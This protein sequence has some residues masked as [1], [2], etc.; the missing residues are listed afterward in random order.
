MKL[1]QKN[2]FRLGEI[3]QQLSCKNFVDE[4][5]FPRYFQ[6]YPSIDPEFT[7]IT[8]FIMVTPLDLDRKIIFIVS[9]MPVKDLWLI[10][11]ISSVIFG[12]RK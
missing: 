11:T 2:V 12:S 4:C 10:F 1:L 8:L 7:N 9:G 6:K 3:H 5:I